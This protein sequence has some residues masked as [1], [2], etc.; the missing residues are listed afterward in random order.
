MSRR[1]AASN[2]PPLSQ[3]HA[4]GERLDFTAREGR[5]HRKGAHADV[6]DGEITQ[7]DVLEDDQARRVGEARSEEVRG[8]PGFERLDG[9][10]AGEGAVREGDVVLVAQVDL[11]AR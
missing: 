10:A 8:G 2:S 3:L 11:Q 1:R 5:G 9:A 6:L 7:V 4:S